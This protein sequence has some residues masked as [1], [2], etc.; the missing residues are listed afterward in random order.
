MNAITCM[1]CNAPTTEADAKLFAE[2]FVCTACHDRAVR[3]FQ[4]LET[5]LRRLLLMSKE[6][7]RAALTEGKLHFE[8]TGEQEVSKA[9]LLKMIVQFSENKER[10]G[11]PGQT[12]G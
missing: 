4:R 5:D 3:I 2:V 10:A 6:A 1:N 9:D 7:I 8:A 11:T 12:R